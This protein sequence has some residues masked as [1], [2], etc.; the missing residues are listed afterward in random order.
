MAR[1]ETA[2]V[3]DRELALLRWI[4]E[5]GGATVGEAAERFG[6]D[7]GLARSTVLTM[8]E[9]L[10]A[11]GLL[12][13][14]RVEKIYSY[15]S[16][17]SPREVMR[18]VVGGFVERTLGG[19]LSP[20]TA[21]LADSEEVSDAELA[22]LEALVAHLRD[23]RDGEP[24]GGEAPRAGDTTDSDATGSEASDGREEER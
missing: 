21:Y 10:R 13:R 16:P 19:S 1:N 9:R 17:A 18:D 6:R 7:E 24:P 15:S 8:M 23:R 12:A 22:E 2:S 20:F 11:K 4:A 14:R 5:R 3:G